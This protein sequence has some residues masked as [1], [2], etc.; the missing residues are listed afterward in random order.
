MSSEFDIL[1]EPEKFIL[2]VPMDVPD[3]VL[4]MWLALTTSS[5]NQQA[6]NS[7]ATLQKLDLSADL[8]AQLNA[9]VS[10]DDFNNCLFVVQS[11]FQKLGTVVDPANSNRQGWLGSHPPIDQIARVRTS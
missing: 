11:A 9:Q 6:L 4:R 10:S 5:Q 3:S 7:A 2:E 8:Y 1:P